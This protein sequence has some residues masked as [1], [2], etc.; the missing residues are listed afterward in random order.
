MPLYRTIYLLLSSVLLFSAC[1]FGKYK[2]MKTLRKEIITAEN[3]KPVVPPQGQSSKYKASIDVLNKH[4]SGIIVLKQTDSETGHLV[5]VTELGM[6]MFE[7][8]VRGDSLSPDFVFEPLNKPSLVKALV[9]SFSDI[10]LTHVFNKE[11]EVKQDKKGEYYLLKDGRNNLV[12][13]KDAS[14]FTG[15]NRVFSGNKKSSKTLY[16]SSYSKISFRTYGLVK[17]RIEMNRITEN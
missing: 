15:V 2:R 11:A 8:V 3:L 6:R 9:K 13:T 12:I 17:L 5:F 4:F 10:L 1:A 7:F 14:N 16:E